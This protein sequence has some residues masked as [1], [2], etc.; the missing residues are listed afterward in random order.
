MFC[1]QK[2]KVA[3]ELKTGKICA[4]SRVK[5]PKIASALPLGYNS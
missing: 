5:T 3:T 2:R 1:G 4:F